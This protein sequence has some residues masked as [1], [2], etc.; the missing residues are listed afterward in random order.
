M[1]FEK[2]DLGVI[3]G[4]QTWEIV[5]TATGDVIGYNQTLPE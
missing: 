1:E 2:I 3:D 4:L 5:D